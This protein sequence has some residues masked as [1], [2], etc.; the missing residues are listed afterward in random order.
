MGSAPGGGQE[1]E[2]D[3]AIC[4]AASGPELTALHAADAPPLQVAELGD[5]Q[6]ASGAVIRDARIGY[7]TAG[8]LNADRSNAVLFP[9]WFTGTSEDLFTSDAVGAVDMSRFFLIAVDALANG[10]SS[11]PSNSA[12]QPKG[13]FPRLTIGDMVRSQHL[14][15]T[16]ERARVNDAVRTFLNR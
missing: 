16:C 5:F 2:A 10:T 3:D 11:S 14:A 12:R 4:A 1:H 7:R 15:V 13:E 9:T 6:L 8:E